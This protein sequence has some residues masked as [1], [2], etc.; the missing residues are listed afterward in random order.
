[1]MELPAADG[2]A[3]LDYALG[4][5]PYQEWGSWPTDDWTDFSEHLAS[6][7]PH[8]NV[9]RIFAN[10]V[11]QK[12]AAA[13]DFDGTLPA[14]SV[15]VK[16]NYMGTDPADPGQVAALTIMNK[17]EGFNPDANDWYWVKAAGDGSAIDKEGAVGGCIGCHSQPNNHDYLLRYGFGEEPAVPSLKM[18]EPPT[19]DG[20]A[21]LDY[22]MDATP[23]Q[24]WGTWPTD[25]WN[26]FGEFLNSGEPHGNIVRIFVNDVAQ[27]AAAAD[28]FDGTLPAGSV[29]LK[30]NYMGTDPADPGQL[31]A[32]T[33]M[34]KVEGFNPDANDWYWVKAAGDGS[35]IDKEGAV[36]GCI[37]CHSQPNNHDYQLRY[38]F[39]EEPAVPTLGEAGEVADKM[40]E[41]AS[42]MD[43]DPAA[44]HV[45]AATSGCLACHSVDGSIVVGPSWQGIFGKTE[46]IEG[47]GTAV[48]DADYLRES[49]VDPA[50]K[51]VAG[52]ANSM[53]TN[54]G[55]TLSADDIANIIAYIESLK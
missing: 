54:F 11:A 25:D 12:A 16:E 32:L 3:I 43:G 8:G 24:S 48:V 50:A 53:P 29:I 51:I 35:A 6:G 2:Q 1:M 21:I 14:G 22:V 17:V 13:D 4:D 10:D 39:G 26:D 31:A 27:K 40:D 55:D 7:E 28:D 41:D 18:A 36:G 49:I 20:Q 42:E 15:I 45:V 46:T 19:A 5:T 44:G 23:Y 33:I 34:N 37:G 30:E 38:G 47:G 52:F 9:V